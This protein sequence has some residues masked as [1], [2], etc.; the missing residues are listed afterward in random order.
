MLQLL[1]VENIC[2]ENLYI[3][4]NY[5]VGVLSTHFRDA[6]RDYRQ[7]CKEHRVRCPS[8]FLNFLSLR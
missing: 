6:A 2:S 5:Q 3:V 7:I 4:R 8:L 1:N